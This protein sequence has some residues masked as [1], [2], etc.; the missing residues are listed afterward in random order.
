[1]KEISADRDIK[2]YK[3]VF[4]PNNPETT[5]ILNLAE[6]YDHIILQSLLLIAEK[7]S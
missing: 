5:Y 2:S 6:T 7:T 4:D 3:K 1:M